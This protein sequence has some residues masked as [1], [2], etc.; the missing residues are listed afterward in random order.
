MTGYMLF[1]KCLLCTGLFTCSISFN[2]DNNT[3]IRLAYP[4]HYREAHRL[5][6]VKDVTQDQTPRTKVQTQAS[7][8]HGPCTYPSA[9]VGN[10][11]Q[12]QEVEE[13][14]GVESGAMLK[15]NSDDSYESPKA[16]KENSPPGQQIERL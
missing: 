12:E 9:F 6:E 11:N 13:R 16:R 10:R 15:M 2:A 1:I 3:T 7:W 5:R 8:T 4:P 14:R